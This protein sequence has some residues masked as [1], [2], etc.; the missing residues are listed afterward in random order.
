MTNV[1]RFKYNGAC[2]ELKLGQLKYFKILVCQSSVP[3]K[4]KS[5]SP[6]LDLKD[7]SHDFYILFVWEI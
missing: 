3:E 7:D 1:I 6:F 4:G 5:C 2:G